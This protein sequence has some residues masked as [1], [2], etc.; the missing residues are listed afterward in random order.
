MD[1][2]NNDHNKKELDIE[3]AEEITPEDEMFIDDGDVT[4]KNIKNVFGWVA[5]ALGL[6]AFFIAP[7][8]F[9]IAGIILGFFARAQGAT[10]LGNSAIVV[11]ILAIALRMFMM[12]FI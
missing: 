2:E 8:L 10:L 3:A 4:D 9:G 5:L 6:I 12:P 7:Y 11:S 1:W